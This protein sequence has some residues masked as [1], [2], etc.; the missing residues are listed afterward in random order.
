MCPKGKTAKRVEF[1]GAY[2]HRHNH[3]EPTGAAIT[4]AADMQHLKLPTPC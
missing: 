4:Q 3:Q 1:L 2:A